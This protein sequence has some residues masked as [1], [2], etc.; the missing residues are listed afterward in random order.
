MKR[1]RSC[2]ISS[3]NKLYST[4]TTTTKEKWH[5]ILLHNDS[6]TTTTTTTAFRHMTTAYTGI[7][8]DGTK[9]ID[10]KLP[11][12]PYQTYINYSIKS[13]DGSIVNH[14]RLVEVGPFDK[15]EWNNGMELM[16][17]IIR[18]GKSWPFD[19]EFQN[20]DE[21]RGYFLSH[22]AFVARAVDEGYDNNGVVSNVG[23]FMGCF[24]IKPN[25]PGRCSHI[26]NGGFITHSKFH[27]QGVGKLMGHVF[28][29]ASKDL[30]Y[31]SSYFNLVFRSNIASVQLWES[32]GF[33]RVATLENAAKLNGATGLDTAYGYRYDLT[34]LPNNYLQTIYNNNK[35]Q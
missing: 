23:D 29:Q 7:P 17:C 3:I 19:N 18:D 15:N 32:L 14:K 28:L 9:D 8:S 2:W 13:N 30:G 24:Y 5:R 26:C 21:Y 6:R 4:N 16:N 1:Q 27:R 10:T 20:I 35:K 22:T 31:L 12:I 33:I 11:W 34:T 25:Y